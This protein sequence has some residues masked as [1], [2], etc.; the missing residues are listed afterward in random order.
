MAGVW[1]LV[2]YHLWVAQSLMCNLPYVICFTLFI[3]LRLSG[4]SQELAK[5]SLKSCSA[6]SAASNE[7]LAR[8]APQRALV[9]LFIKLSMSV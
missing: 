5:R 8:E 7:V 3:K 1:N 6:R 9:T 4:R 2:D